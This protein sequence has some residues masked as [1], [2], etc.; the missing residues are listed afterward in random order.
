MGE[1]IKIYQKHQEVNHFF[2]RNDSITLVQIKDFIAVYELRSLSRAADLLSKTQP[3][4]SHSLAKLEEKLSTQLVKRQRG[5]NIDFTEEGHRFYTDVS[6]LL[7]KL[8]IKIDEIESK[9][10]ITIGLPDDLDMEI[11]LKL[12]R[13]ISV[14]IDGRLRF[15]CGFSDNIIKMVDSGRISFGIIKETVKDG[16]LHYGWAGSH[17]ATTFS[18]YRKLPLV[19]GYSGCIIRDMV[20]KTLNHANKDFYFVYL[21]NRIQHR[22]QAVAEGFGVGVFSKARIKR[23]KELLPLD[24]ARGF[25]DLASFSYRSIGEADT[26]QKKQ[27]LPV[28]LACVKQLNN[29]KT[30]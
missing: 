7:D 1:Y 23:H 13:D 15:I 26:A 18:D 3:A 27:I 20:Q 10:T 11:Q 2:T 30:Q 8:L 24:K 28:L 25:P 9:N 29:K 22:V 14:L 19:S 17:Q 6:P 16:L 4:I 12:Y 21:S 5:K